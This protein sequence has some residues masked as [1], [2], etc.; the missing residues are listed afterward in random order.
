MSKK[1]YSENKYV[2]V[3]DLND[4]D[5]E[6]E[7]ENETY[8]RKGHPKK[9]KK[10]L[11]FEP[12]DD[13]E[14][15]EYDEEDGEAG[16]DED[17]EDYDDDEYDEE[18]YDEKDDDE[19]DY[20]DDDYVEKKATAKTNK[21]DRAVYKGIIAFF[22]IIFSLMSAYF[23]YF[24]AFKAKD[25]ASNPYNPRMSALSSKVTRGT[26]YSSDGEIL[27][28]T[29]QG[30]DGNDVREYPYGR[31]FAHAVGYSVNG[32]MGVELSENYTLL[33]SSIDALDKA[34]G[35]VTGE[36]LP[37][38]SVV[39]TY[40]TALQGIAYKGLGDYA[41]AVVAIEPSTGKILCMVSNPDFDPNTISENWES[42]TSDGS[43]V[44]VNR[45]AQGLYPPGSTFKILTALEY[46]DEGKDTEATITCKGKYKVTDDYTIHCAKNERHG[47]QNI[48]EAFANSC[49]VFFGT[50]GL[51]LNPSEFTSLS[52]RLLFNKPLP[53]KLKNTSIS[54]FSIKSSDTDSKKVQ[55]AI[56]QSDTVVT[57]LHM[58]MI[59][60]AIANGGI[61]YEPYDVDYVLSYDEK[62][63]SENKP[64]EYKKL[65]SD[66]QVS[67][68]RDYM[69]YAVTNGTARKLQSDSYDAYG[70]TGTAEYTEDKDK[71]HSWFTGFAER[72]G[73]QIAVAVI[74]EGAGTGSKHAVPL[75]KEIFD[76]YFNGE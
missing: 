2:D 51:E 40:D 55:V 73:K 37:G 70:K 41:G 39:T 67:E 14:E 54:K 11:F 18:D 20:E 75:A 10:S 74:M 4:D 27:A 76:Y 31:E 8:I 63:V 36:K 61:L 71:T 64:E 56:G 22:I 53:T 25:F 15:D 16:Y 58:C 23:V 9:K 62:V 68:L 30:S 38:D 47:K 60:S 46:L 29:K 6:K 65:L 28:V 33:N 5:E 69:R 50:I 7:D 48:K 66:I 12:I 17:E 35:S 45:A 49:N 1:R 13:E 57:P 19:V 52:E 26:I 34:K 3:M 21:K 43:S 32:M 59:S 44:L 72:D 24:V 42:L